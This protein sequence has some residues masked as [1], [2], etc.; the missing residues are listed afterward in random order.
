ML[1]ETVVQLEHQLLAATRQTDSA[2]QVASCLGIQRYHR[3]L[4]ACTFSQ[5]AREVIVLP[6]R[7]LASRVVEEQMVLQGEMQAVERRQIQAERLCAAAEL[8]ASTLVGEVQM[9]EAR[10]GQ[11]QRRGEESK[12]ELTEARA[13]IDHLSA[14]ITA[15]DE[16]I[17][18]HKA[19]AKLTAMAPCQ[20]SREACPLLTA[21]PLPLPLP[22][23]APPPTPC[24]SPAALP[25]P[26]S[27]SCLT[28][29]TPQHCLHR[30]P[31]PLP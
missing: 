21:L 3:R 13:E 20:P 8:H 17:A 29:S 28:L 4:L 14:E 1:Q 18:S 26:R 11:L 30:P 22:L 10:R 24:P 16:Q 9:L 31:R 12:L 19:E 15:R 6:A 2:L 5:W 7:A 27:A 23:P 25:M